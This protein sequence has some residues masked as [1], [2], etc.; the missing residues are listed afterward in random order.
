VERAV[1]NLWDDIPGLG[2]TPGEDLGYPTQKTT[3]LLERVIRTATNPGDLVLDC[4]M[5]S[6]TTLAVAQQLGRRW[7]G[8]DSHYGALQ[9]TRR[10]LQAQAGRTPTADQAFAVYAINGSAPSATTAPAA[11]VRIERLLEQP[12]TIEVEILKVAAPAIEELCAN[13]T[14]AASLDES[15]WRAVV[16]CVAIDPAYNGQFFRSR[17]VDAPLKKSAQVVGRYTFVAPQPTVVAVRVTDLL[18]G[19]VIHTAR[20]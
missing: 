14:R 2:I 7:I 11:T 19:E 5:G 9:T 8:C 4:F 1:D 3:A 17:L 13:S 20:V 18:G 12:A 16:D 10:R 6:G 15:G